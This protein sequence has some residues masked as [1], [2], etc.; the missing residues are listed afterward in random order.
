MVRAG[1]EATVVDIGHFRVSLKE[2]CDGHAVGAV[3]LHP[4]V[5]ALKAEVQH[6]G[7]HGGLH[8]AEVA[9]ELCGGLGDESTLFAEALR[10]GDAMIALIG[11]TQAGELL[12][13]GHPVEL[14]AVHDGTAQ[15]S[16]MAVHILGGGMGHD[17]SAPLEGAAVNR[18][19]E[20]VVHDERY[21]VGVCGLG[22]LF[23]VQHGEGRVGDGLTKHDLGVGPEGGIQLF[24]AAQ[25]V[26]EGG[27]N[28]HLLHGDGDEVEGA[29]VDG[30]GRHDVVACLADIEQRK[31]VG[32]LTAGRQHGGGASFQLADLFRHHI[33]GGV[34]QAGVEVAVGLEVE[35]LAHVLAGSVLERSGLDDGDL[36][37]F[38]VAGGVAALHAD[39]IT[40]H[41][42][43]LLYWVCLYSTIPRRSMSLLRGIDSLNF[44]PCRKQKLTFSAAYHSWSP[45]RCRRSGT[46]A[47]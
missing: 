14:A 6:I 5:E 40:V 39:G 23:N 18:R 10:V 41:C 12:G 15:H 1:L 11:S 43:I 4:D 32:S 13:M 2:L 47:P 36:A 34:L 26:H 16:A 37:G 22:E 42:N 17:V 27:G 44:I 9:H 7:V 25:R 28:A 38:A 3:A 8:R 33:A 21:A 20:S 29:A 31:E 45:R 24:L 30:A 35:Q 19:G 46:P